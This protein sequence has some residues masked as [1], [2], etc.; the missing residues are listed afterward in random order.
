V[1][2]DEGSLRIPAATLNS[3]LSM[4]P[5]KYRIALGATLQRADGMDKLLRLHVGE[6][7]IRTK[8]ALKS[9]AVV[10]VRRYKASWGTVPSHLD[11]M[12][13]RGIYLG[14]VENDMARSLMIA[15]DVKR[16]YNSEGRRVVVMSDRTRLLSNVHSLLVNS[17]KIPIDEIGYYC[18]SL[19]YGKNL[20]RSVSKKE[21][22]QT[23]ANCRIILA[24]FPMMGAGTN[25]PDLS[26]LILATPQVSSTQSRGRIE[27]Y[28]DG[29]AQPIVI[30]Y[31]DVR[32]VDA[33]RWAEKRQEEYARAGLRVVIK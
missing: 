31:V 20:K 28:L 33:L 4:F 12:V 26:G 16:F 24:T 30:D 15:K 32:H 10:M 9:P 2:F 13:R 5:A 1:V 6:T 29:K 8:E 27:R 7:T 18:N 23:L 25:V 3:V 17:M 22:E 11:V 19:V 21:R 14:L